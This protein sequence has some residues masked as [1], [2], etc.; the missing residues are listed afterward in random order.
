MTLTPNRFCSVVALIVV[1]LACPIARAGGESKG[2][3]PDE[4]G[5]YLDERETDWFAYANC[6]SCHT[7]LPYALARPALRKVAGA[8]TP[9]EQETKLLAQIRL[10]VANW[11][12]LDSKEFGLYY[13]SS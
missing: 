9:T 6:V 7:G 10:R 11:K 13:D 2:W 1:F 5:K 3:K 8:E 4:A 12:K